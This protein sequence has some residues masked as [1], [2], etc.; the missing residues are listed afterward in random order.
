MKA[1]RHKDRPSPSPTLGELINTVAK[2][3]HN[4]RLSA[5]VVADLV[6]TGRIRFEGRYHGRRVVIG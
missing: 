2:L 3:A 1:M 4:E 6:N 5:V